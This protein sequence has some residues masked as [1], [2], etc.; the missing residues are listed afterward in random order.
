MVEEAIKF[1][2]FM[3]TYH[4]C[5]LCNVS[6]LWEKVSK[7]LCNVS[8]L[9]VK[10]KKLPRL[11]SQNSPCKKISHHRRKRRTHLNDFYLFIKLILEHEIGGT[12]VDF[13]Q[14]CDVII[15]ELFDGIDCFQDLY[16]L[17]KE[18][19]RRILPEGLRCRVS[20]Y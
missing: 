19:L 2:S 6:I 17:C 4:K 11:F 14:I 18:R 13:N 12:K 5:H 10:G 20:L 1:F 7:A 3:G 15:G 8:I 16:F 9:W